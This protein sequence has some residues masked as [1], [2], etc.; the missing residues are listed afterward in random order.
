VVRWYAWSRFI[1]TWAYAGSAA[2]AAFVEPAL[3]VPLVLVLW[4]VVA[5]PQ[6][7]G[8]V[9]FP[10]V[11]DGAAGPQGRVDL[12]GRRWAIMGLGTAVAVAVAGAVLDLLGMPTGYQLV[13]VSGTIA[14]VFTFWYSS[15]IV[16]DEGRPEPPPSANVAPLPARSLLRSERPFTAF[17][18][19]KAVFVA[20]VRLVAPL[21]PLYYVDLLGASDAWIG[22]IAMAQGLALVAGYVFWRRQALRM[23]PLTL[24][25]ITLAVFGAYPA[26]FAVTT[27]VEVV[28]VVTAVGAFFAAGSDLALFDELMARIPRDRSVTFAGVDH[29]ITNLA[30]IV[31]PLAG[32]ALVGVVGLGWG[33]VAG[34]VVSTVGLGM[35]V[36]AGPRRPEDRPADVPSPTARPA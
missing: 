17:V 34:A 33:L 26:V 24:L 20:G 5:L 23:R 19:R 30:G 10:I 11:M 14:G 27:S 35:F 25:L 32:A 22:I 16:L 36:R 3:V 9:T 13:L 4:A 6:T 15:R 31:A 7:M 1:V 12:M 21:L 18:A 8:Q 29:A 2:I 28:V